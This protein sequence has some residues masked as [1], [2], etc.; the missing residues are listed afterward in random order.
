[1]ELDHSKATATISFEGLTIFCINDNHQCEA[2]F[3]SCQNHDLKLTIRV[4]LPNGVKLPIQHALSFDNE[5]SI[6]VVNPGRKGIRFYK[7]GKFD[8]RKSRGEA[9]DFRW[10]LDIEGSE[11][12]DSPLAKAAAPSS[13]VAAKLTPKTVITD[14]VLYA[15]RLPDEKLAR[16]QIHPTPSAPVFLGKAADV[17]GLDVFCKDGGNSGVILGNKD[18]PESQ[19]K[20]PKVDGIRYEIEFKNDCEIQAAPVGS[21]DF[22]VYYDVLKDAKG[23]KFDLRDVVAA[24]DPRA[25][26]D[27]FDDFP[28]FAPNERPQVCGGVFL[29]LTTKI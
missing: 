16:E 7:N 24:G 5:L 3:L 18:V 8:R 6:E 19:L 15:F 17:I 20:L 23:I 11:F 29:G 26:G 28:L 4:V 25:T 10:V 13:P 2:A 9:E 12:H 14:G 21:S 1:M 22:S 27:P